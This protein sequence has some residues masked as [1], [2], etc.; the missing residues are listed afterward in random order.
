MRREDFFRVGGFDAVNTPIRHSDVDLSFKIRAAGLR[1][2][3]TPYA[4]LYHAGHV[5]IGRE[6]KIPKRDKASI[7]LLKRWPEFTTRDPF[8]PDNMRDWL[9]SDSPIPIRMMARDEPNAAATSP[10]LLFVSHDLSLSGAPIMLFHAARWCHENGLFV[11]VLAPKDG[12]IRE[13]LYDLG[14]PVLIDPLVASGHP[15]FAHFARDFDC[16][17]ANSLRSKTVAAAL[18]KEAVPVVW[19]IHEP[20][21][22]GEHYLREDA[23]LRAVLPLAEL[24]LA[25]SER[26]ARIYRPF[27]DRPVKVLRNAIPD[28]GRSAR[29]KTH[30]AQPLRFILLASIEPR[31]GQDIFAEAVASLPAEL[32]ETAEFQLA[33]RILDP[34]FWLKVDRIAAPLKKFSVTGALDHADAIEMLR[35]ADVIVCA[36]RDEAMPVV[37]LE[38]LSLGKALIT[39]TVGGTLEM[40]V[41]G[42]DALLVRPEAPDA[43]AAAIRR[44][45]ENPALIQQLGEKA[46][47]TYERQFT[48]N[49]FGHDFRALIDEAMAHS[50]PRRAQVE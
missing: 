1:C 25:P 50:A 49:R 15:S 43:L 8:F 16:V 23:E 38:A 46:R 34:D 35:S 44:L 41:D 12:P 31:K 36:S 14:V 27:T 26:T 18:Q 42:E 19:W 9:Y 47:E 11:V 48:L 17:L 24:V 10:D 30:E 33:G 45:L 22:V 32:R 2:V 6:E 7:Y 4:T 39:T 28:L 29:K 5:S 40:L 3:Y 20:G 13:K 21:S 37:I